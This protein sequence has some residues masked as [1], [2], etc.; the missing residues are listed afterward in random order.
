MNPNPNPPAGEV[1]PPVQISLRNPSLAAFLAWLWPGAGHIYQRRYGKGILFMVCVLGTYFFGLGIGEGRVVYAS[2]RKADFRYPYL[3]QVAVGAPALPAAVQYRRVIVHEQLPL[4]NG[5]M[6]PPSLEPRKGHVE[7][8]ALHKDLGRNFELGTLYTMIAGLLNILV[9]FDAYGGPAFPDEAPKNR[10]PGA[11]AR[12][13]EPPPDT[14][15]AQR[16]RVPLKS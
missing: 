15:A 12:S 2:F 9:I 10:S 5:M 3:L 6:A 13:G 7:L 1:E 16:K 14:E 4:W 11:A 8:S